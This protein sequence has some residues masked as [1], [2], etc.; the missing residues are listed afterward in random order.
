MGN[1]SLGTRTVLEMQFNSDMVMGMDLI[2]VL[3]CF[4]LRVLGMEQADPYML[5]STSELHLQLLCSFIL[6]QCFT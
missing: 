2:D 3:V 1:S 5:D 4:H 6:K